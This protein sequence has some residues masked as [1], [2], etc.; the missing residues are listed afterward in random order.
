[1]VNAQKHKQIKSLGGMLPL[2]DKEK[3]QEIMIFYLYSVNENP[4]FV[5]AE[6]NSDYGELNQYYYGVSGNNHYILK[7]G[8]CQRILEVYEHVFVLNDLI[9]RYNELLTIDSSILKSITITCKN[10]INTFKDIQ[11]A[12][13]KNIKKTHYGINGLKASK[14]LNNTDVPSEIFENVVRLETPIFVGGD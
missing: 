8:T 5:L 2:E 7:T 12:Q 1:M 10:I 6:L 3:M 9:Q 13:N 4:Q 11:S 14:S